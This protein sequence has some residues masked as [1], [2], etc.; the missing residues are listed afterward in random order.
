MIFRDA[1]RDEVPAI[2][3]LL[4][5]DILGADRESGLDGAYWKAFDDIAA[6]P[7]SRLIVADVEGQVAGMLQLTV[8]PG[9]SRHG[10]PRAQIEGVRVAAPWR[11]QGLGR[12]M[13]SWAI[14]EGRRNGCG[15]VQL[16]S[17]KRRTDAIRFYE[18]L[19]FTPTMKASSNS[20][21]Q[22]GRESGTQT[23]MAGRRFAVTVSPSGRYTPPRAQQKSGISR[24]DFQLT[25]SQGGEAKAGKKGQRT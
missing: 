16:T 14:E 10:M 9:L 22:L 20:S 21:R 19:G 18:A 25:S 5:D 11:G 17:D 2:V 4:A 15:L 24:C 3:S 1:R 6:D 7:R 23:S 13:V 8:I 12:A